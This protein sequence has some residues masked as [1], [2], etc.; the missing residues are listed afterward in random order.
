MKMI[1]KEEPDLIFVQEPYEYQNRPVGIEKK[2]RIF[3][4]GNGKQSRHCYPEQ[5]NRCHALYTDIERI[6]NIF[7]NSTRKTKIFAVS[8]YIDIEEQIENSFIKIDEI[9]QFAKVARILKAT[10][11]NARSK[12]WHDKITNTRGKILKE[13]LASRHL[14][15]INEQS[16]K[17]TFHNNRS[18]SNIDFTITNNKLIADVQEWEIGEKESCSDHNFLKYKIVKAKSYKNKYNYRCIRYTIKEDK[19]YEYDLKLEQDTKIF[20]NIIYKVRVVEMDM[21]LSTT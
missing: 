5:K 18:S 9:L 3:P 4:A 2:C 19:Y 20:K 12:T 21:N 16:E 6:R 1:E 14:H 13:Y 15:I 10:D 11:S 7:R 8:I 17:F